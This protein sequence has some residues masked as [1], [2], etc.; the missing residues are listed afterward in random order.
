MK[1]NRLVDHFTFMFNHCLIK[2]P[3]SFDS[4]QKM[5]LQTKKEPSILS[6]FEYLR[7]NLIH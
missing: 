5:L 3:K 2:W 6:K 4:R 1:K 7:K